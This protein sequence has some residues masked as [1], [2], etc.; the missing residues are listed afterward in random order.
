MPNRSTRRS[1]RRCAGLLPGVALAAGCAT[2]PPPA[3]PA[4]P[5]L[6]APAAPVCESGTLGLEAG[7]LSRGVRKRLALPADLRG[8]VVTEVLDGG[9][10][11]RAGIRPDDVLLSIGEKSLDNEC[12]LVR[13][14]WSLPCRAVRAVVVRSGARLAID[15]DP[16]EEGAF[17][18]RLCGAGNP[19]ACFRQAWR[20]YS[21]A[22]D[23]AEKES[24]LGLLEAACRSGSAEACAYAGHELLEK[25]DRSADALSTLTRSCDLG[26]GSGCAHLAYLYATGTLVRRDDVRATALYVRSCD[27][28]DGMGCYNVGLMSQHGRGTRADLARAVAA[29]EEGC[30]GGSPGACTNLGYFFEHGEGVPKDRA[31]A[32]ELY[33]RGCEGSS[34][35]GPNLMGCVNLGR[36]FRD[37]IGVGKDATRA[38]SIFRDA[39]EEE[40]R[41]SDVPDA[42]EQRWRA[43]SLLG[44]LHLSG[45]GVEKDETAGRELSERGCAGGDAFGCFN[46]AVAFSSGLGVAPDPARAAFFYGAACDA[47]DGE[48]CHESG[49]AYEKGSGVPRDARRAADLFRKACSAGFAPACARKVKR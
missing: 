43:C 10:A 35:R 47:G 33:R 29:Y 31:R 21:R 22:A 37:G 48:G 19:T 6:S 13:S 7:A 16:V 11:A 3:S 34:C 24:A 39:C 12:D 44:A 41:E 38:A 30:E 9:P 14:A 40:P 27:R 2:A 32:V 36:A 15:L 42:A 49:L 45:D 25:S 23:A 4:S 17:L 5:A 46:A 18:G 26:S 8:A 28:G 20:S 1:V